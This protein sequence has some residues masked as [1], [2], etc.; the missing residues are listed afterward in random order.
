MFINVPLCEGLFRENDIV[1]VA[2]M[3]VEP[4]EHFFS[5]VN[6]AFISCVNYYSLTSTLISYH[7]GI[8]MIILKQAH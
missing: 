4:C 5:A 7:V 6:A 2:A 8:I 1:S 3:T